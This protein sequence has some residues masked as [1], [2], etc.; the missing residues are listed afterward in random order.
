MTLC[1]KIGVEIELMAPP[2]RSRADLAARVAARHGGQVRR[3]FHPQSEPSETPGHPTFD[4]LTPGF[5]AVD[6]EGRRIASFVDDLTLQAGLNRT[7]RPLPGWYRVVADDGR[8]LRLAMRHCDPDA[9]LESALDPLAALF[10]TVPTRHDGGMVRVADDRGISVAIGA[11]LPGERERPCEI[12]TAPIESDHLAVLDGL[13]GEARALGF[14]LPREGATHLHFD[15]GPMLS[16]TAIAALVDVY[17]AHGEALKRL[18]GVNPNCIR[19]GAWPPALIQLTRSAAFRAMSWPQ[20]CDA[21]KTVGL[22]KYCDINLLNVAMQLSAK[23]TIE[24]R[25]LP[26][27]LTAAPIIDAAELFE[28]LLNWCRLPETSAVP[29]TISALID[30]LPLSSDAATM[31]TNKAAL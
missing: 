18:V 17:A 13:L 10:G 14:T 19:L 8:M 26:S 12:V 31:W 11:P 29:R 24:I 28:A 21:L 4:N 9:P 6:G 23:H 3:F 16:A 7:A 2:G 20:A 30:E 25:I 27:W 22:T 5:E 1:W 15:A